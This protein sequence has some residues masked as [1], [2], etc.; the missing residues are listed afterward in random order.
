MNR[1]SL[2]TIEAEIAT[3]AKREVKD[4]VEIGGLLAEAKEQLDDMGSGCHGSKA[5]FRSQSEPL[6]TTWRPIAF[7]GKYETVSH[8]L[9]SQS[10]GFMPS[11]TPIETVIS[12]AVEVALSRSERQMG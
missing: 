12:E 1:R 3:V 6:K 4:A 9:D 8:M 11:S 2:K 5:I 10:V 7:A